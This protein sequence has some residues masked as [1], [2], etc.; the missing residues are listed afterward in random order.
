MV[1]DTISF[2]LL[3]VTRDDYQ[4]SDTSGRASKNA[5][6]PTSMQNQLVPLQNQFVLLLSHC[7]AFQANLEMRNVSV[8]KYIPRTF[9]ISLFLLRFLG[10]CEGDSLTPLT[11]CL[12]LG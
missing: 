12:K 10:R 3:V 11:Q 2:L 7:P 4:L 1:A 8:S 5:S 9:E 6:K